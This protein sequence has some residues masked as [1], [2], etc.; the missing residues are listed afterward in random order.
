M[1][2][3]PNALPTPSDR[4]QRVEGGYDDATLLDIYTQY[5]KESFDGRI[6]FERQILKVIWYVLRRQWIYYN[7]VR[8]EWTDK[9]LAK[10]I[11]RPVSPLPDEAVQTIRAMFQS[12]KL[13][14]TVRPNGGDPENVAAA[15]VCDSLIPLLYEEHDMD[16]AMSEF[17]WWLIVAGNAFLYSYWDYD[18]KYGATTITL[19]QCQ[20]CGNAYP[21]NELTGATP[22]CPDCG[23]N[24][25]QTATNPMTG[26]PVQRLEPNGKGVT[27]ALSPLEVA[28]PNSYT[29]F[30]DWP[31][32]FVLRWRARSYYENHPD[33][34]DQVSK[35]RWQKTPQDR[36]LQI[37]KS[38]PYQND[39][40][41][42]STGSSAGQATEEEGCAEL[43]LWIRP[44]QTYPKGCVF[45]VVNDDMVL[46]IPSEHLPGPFPYTDIEGNPI[47]TFT[48]A[49]YKHVGGRTFGE[50][51]LDSALTLI[52]Q[53]NQNN[54][55]IQ[56][57]VQRM[58]NPI[59]VVPKGA[60]IQKFTGEPGFQLEWNPLTVGG[61]AKPER[62]DGLP[63]NPS[64]VQ[65]VEMYTRLWEEATG[66]L[67]VLKGI[68]PGSDMPFSAMQL[69]V[70]RGQARFA[71]VFKARGAAY[72]DVVKFQLELERDF[73][74]VERTLPMLNPT[75]SY[76][77][78]AFKNAQLQGAFSIIVEDGSTAPK[79]N[80]GM[81]AAMEHANQLGMLDMTDPDQKYE[82]LKLM[83]LTRMVPSLDVH[84]Q[85][86]LQKQEAFERWLED[87][88]AQQ[89]SFQQA[90]EQVAQYEES[91]QTIQAPE[92]SL[93]PDNDGMAQ[94]PLPPPPSPTATTP[95]KWK[96]WY[97]PVVHRQE[98][99]KWA[100]SDR[101]RELMQQ[102]PSIEPLLE[103]HL[104]EIDQ[105][106][107]MAM[108]QQPQPGQP[109]QPKK[110]GGAGAGMNNSNR[111]ST[112]G[113]EPSGNK[114]SGQNQG[115]A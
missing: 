79:S 72:R 58:S 1:A 54:S 99:V 19:E 103:A 56:M 52:D 45:R 83:G 71:S 90:E 100:N 68:K 24:V 51:A 65:L 60:G 36:S 25:F 97:S 57:G 102:N 2:E 26:E 59:W 10:W 39:I 44:C 12:I 47:L 11:P 74:P 66:T 41:I 77:F 107:A 17:D 105:A 28:G 53:I 8:G 29:R 94:S 106:I 81:R 14:V 23:G 110:P 30:S 42:V 35:I 111:E 48:H 76:T 91:L 84:V 86:A 6:H 4:S 62:L 3:S 63:V 73:G 104:A 87:P 113:N 112:Q 69:L 18:I 33:L 115:P 78:E 27:V 9:R 13:D 50:G 114:E 15:A 31:Y 64:L 108:P 70:E 5:K 93:S 85:A 101:M 61:N 40:G 96:P 80:L 38:L 98:F 55:M 32:H 92:P 89:A 37:F 21:S 16:A 67:D 46:Q 22:T 43:E 109:N 7:S 95:L 49:T 75:K 34:K 82:G 20:Q 88:A